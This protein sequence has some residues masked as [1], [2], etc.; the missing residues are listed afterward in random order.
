LS[1][2]EGGVQGLPNISDLDASDQSVSAGYY[3]AEESFTKW[4]IFK[5]SATEY[6]G[7]TI[8]LAAESRSLNHSS[9]RTCAK[10]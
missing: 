4:R 9:K 3:S 5:R 1:L 8:N 6:S 2:T 7:Q 10:R